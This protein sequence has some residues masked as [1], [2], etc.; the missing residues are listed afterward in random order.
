MEILHKERGIAS[1]NILIGFVVIFIGVWLLTT[2][3][4]WGHRHWLHTIKGISSLI[5]TSGYLL[6]SLSIFLAS[7]WS[8]LDK[9]FGGLDKIYH[10][11]HK[12]GIVGFLL[13]AIH[14]WVLGLKWLPHQL[15]QFFLS[16]LPIHHRLSVNF[17]SIAYFLLVILVLITIFKILP[18]DKWKLTH[19]FMSLVFLLASLHILLSER[20]FGSQ[21]LSHALLFIPMSLGSF[22]IVYRQLY[23]PLFL[24]CFMYKVV[25]VDYLNNRVI[26]ISLTTVDRAIKYIAGQ[27]V[28]VSFKEKGVTKESHP[29]TLT[30]NPGEPQISLL[31]KSRG[32]FT[33]A[34]YQNIKAGSEALLEGPYGC[35]DLKSSDLPQIWIAG[36]VGIA[37]FV[38]WA[39]QLGK[40]RVH[41]FYS[42]HCKAEAI[43]L[44]FF[45]KLSQENSNFQYSLFCSEEGA[46]LTAEGVTKE[47]SLENPLILMCGPRRMTKGLSTQF[48]LLGFDR[49]KILYEDFEFL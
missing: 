29:F 43:H 7:R 44:D 47:C 28:F 19:K 26:E 27:Y 5:A 39:K 45:Q 40:Q 4:D 20:R 37:P 17:G 36:G 48:C 11:H 30:S 1:R 15:D 9:L 32:D 14:P 31:I 25:K 42:F 12:F 6:F 34:L 2:A 23:A 21:Y 22:G 35:F 13:I 24:K 38:A 3:G 49:K 41:L 16:I 8:L 18:Y 33:N 46:Y 10:L